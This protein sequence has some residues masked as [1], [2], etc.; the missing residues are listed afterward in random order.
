MLVVLLWVVM[1]G[2]IYLLGWAVKRYSEKP[3][4]WLG[5]RAAPK[6]PPAE[7]S[8]KAGSKAAARNPA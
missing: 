1:P 3:P 2:L 8:G 5:F 7:P 6:R 4:S